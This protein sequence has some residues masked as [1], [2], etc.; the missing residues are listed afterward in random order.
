MGA[1]QGTCEFGAVVN[2]GRACITCHEDDWESLSKKTVAGSALEPSPI[3]GKNPL[4][5]LGVKAARDADYLYFRFSWKTNADREGR[6][7]NYVRHD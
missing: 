1:H 7:H 6:M 5:K 2:K 3:A 4:I